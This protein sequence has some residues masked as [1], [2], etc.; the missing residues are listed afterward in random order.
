M[1]RRILYLISS[2]AQGGAQRHL[3]ELIG[4]LDPSRYEAAIC[5]MKDV[6][7]FAAEFPGIQP[8]Y[9]LRSPMFWAPHAVV[10]LVRAL[11]DFQPDVLHSHMNDANLW[12]RLVLPWSHPRPRAVVT[13]VHLDDMTRLHRFWEHRLHGRSD[14]IIAVS[15]GVR[16][17][18]VDEM[19]LPPGEVDVIVNGVDV[20]RFRP[21]D[22]DR[23]ARAR[24]ALG[25]PADAFLALMPARITPQKNQDLVVETLAKMKA[26]GAL[27]PRFRLL[28]AGAISSSAM[29]ARIDRI[30]ADN[31][32]ALHVQRLGAVKDMQTLYW[33]SD[34]VAMPSRSEG[35]SLAAFE[36]MSAGLPVL[37]SDT[38]NTDGVIVPGEHGWQ[39]IANDRADLERALLEALAAGAPELERL[40]ARARRRIET[41]YTN[42]RVADD[43]MRLYDRLAG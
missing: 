3:L 10:Q 27:P 11:R 18:L 34:L 14:R 41:G 39:V 23:R 29:S 12:A 9:K 20:A 36:G 42:Q 2:L 4:C 21:V 1:K 24:A 40:G 8:R 19:G 25:F 13:S 43:F 6:N 35:S 5:V 31:H 32:L 33:A 26:G 38:G 16:R 37:I 7:H 30:V 28:L 17:M 15:A 22:A